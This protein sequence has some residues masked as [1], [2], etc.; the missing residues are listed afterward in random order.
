MKHKL[1]YLPVIL[2]SLV[3]CN[4]ESYDFS[5]SPANPRAGE[6]VTFTN[7]STD[8]DEWAWEFGDIATSSLK[9]PTH[10][11]KRPGT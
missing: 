1:L 9:S 11:Y 2:L 3:A 5:Y 8:G 6:T 7:L 10:I 4:R